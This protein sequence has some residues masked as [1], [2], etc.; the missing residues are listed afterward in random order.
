[1]PLIVKPRQVSSSSGT[2]QV[3]SAPSPALVAGRAPLFSPSTPSVK[4][5]PLSSD[6][7]PLSVRS[8]DQASRPRMSWAGF[9]ALKM[10]KR[11]ARAAGLP[12]A[13]SCHTFRATG[14]PAFL[15]AGGTIENGSGHRCARIAEDDQ[16]LRPHERHDHARRGRANR[17]LTKVPKPVR[18]TRSPAVGKSIIPSPVLGFLRERPADGPA[19]RGPVKASFYQIRKVSRWVPRRFADRRRAADPA[20]VGRPS[21]ESAPVFRSGACRSS[22]GFPNQGHRRQRS[23][24]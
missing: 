11:R 21:S 14:I 22:L 10:I 23:S 7:P 13:I 15:E 9:D 17:D 8:L 2:G 20:S 16:A 4:S 19:T 18:N 6:R 1:M 3:A 5:F 24:T 12:A